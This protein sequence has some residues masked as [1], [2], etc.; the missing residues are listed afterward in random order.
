MDVDRILVAE[1]AFLSA[2]HESEA[3]DMLREVL[4]RERNLVQFL[5]IVEFECLEV[6]EQRVAGQFGV[7]QAWEVVQRLRLGLG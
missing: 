3:L 4:Q 7:F 1:G 2:D 5:Q 6:A